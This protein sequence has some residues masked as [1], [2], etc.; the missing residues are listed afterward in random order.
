MNKASNNLIYLTGFMGSGKSTIGPILA[1]TLGFSFI[2]IDKEIIRRAGKP[3]TE[4]FSDF[5]EQQFREM[6]HA[7]L[8]EVSTRVQTVIALGGG[9]VAFERN[10]TIIR[11][12]GTLVYLMADE[13]QLV[14]RLKRKSDRPLLHPASQNVPKEDELRSSIKSLINVREKYYSQ[15]DITISTTGKSVGIT[16]DELVKMLKSHLK[17][18][19]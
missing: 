12:T 9:S 1:N 5:G 15:A 4:I 3:I 2:D 11:S 19:I 18:E 10:M 6:E 16:I 17:F 7:L 13:G 8:K 14:K